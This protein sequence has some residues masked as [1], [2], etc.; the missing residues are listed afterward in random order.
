MAYRYLDGQGNEVVLA[1]RRALAHRIQIG[2]V[3]VSTLI[4]DEDREEWVHATRH[5]AYVELVEG[6]SGDGFRPTEL[7]VGAPS[8]NSS[9]FEPFDRPMANAMRGDVARPEAE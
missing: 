5:P 4:F 3:A 2:D 9:S 8:T 1:D 6:A 7:A